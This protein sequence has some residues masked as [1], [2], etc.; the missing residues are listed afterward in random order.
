[1]INEIGIAYQRSPYDPFVNETQCQLDAELMKTLGCNAIRCIVPSKSLI[2][3]ISNS[4]AYHV[5]PTGDHDGCM[6]TFSDAGIYLF[7]DID[8][9]T[10]QIEE[11][12]P[13]WTYGQ[14]T[15]FTAVI[16]AFAKYDN[17]AGFFVA[18]EVAS[19]VFLR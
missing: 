11:T 4:L 3:L 17:L 6:Q 1:V 19:S 7:L 8:T 16:D 13:Q 5:D 10:T 15:A 9:F 2:F 12:N 18:N 14:Y